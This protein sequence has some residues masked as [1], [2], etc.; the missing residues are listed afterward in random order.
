[1]DQINLEIQNA[2]QDL[3]AN[4]GKKLHQ[5]CDK[6][7]FKFGGISQMDLDDFYS[8]VG[9]EISLVVE[10]YEN[11]SLKY[12]PSCGKTFMEYLSG[13]IRQ[14][15]WKELTKKNRKKRCNVTEIEECDENGNIKKVKKYIPDLSLDAPVGDEETKIV[16]LIA[17]DF[18]FEN[19]I[20]GKIEDMYSQKMILYLNR[21]SVVQKEMLRLTIAGYLPNEI[22]EE[23]HIT[24][25]QYCDNYAA[26]HS[27]RNVSVLF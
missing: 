6:E 18:N 25:K 11:G 5:I 1:M 8:R 23:L 13:V 26:I 21:L 9:W 22:R 12:D 24:E 19:E 16:D 27:Y 15:I 10:K 3:Y 2:I 7:I 14:A 20:F 4:N 17:D